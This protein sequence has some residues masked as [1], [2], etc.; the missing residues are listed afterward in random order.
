MSA[1]PEAYTSKY[2]SGTY[3][4]VFEEV[5]AEDLE[6]VGEIPKD[7][8]GHF[9]RIGPNPYFVPDMERYHIFDGD[10]MIHGVHLENGRATY[11]NKFIDSAGSS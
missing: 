3:E 10:G 4:P 11:R 2:L 8:S 9:L 7:L 6:V 1:K 5:V